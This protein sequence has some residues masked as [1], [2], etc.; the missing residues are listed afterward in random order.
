MRLATFTTGSADRIGVVDVN[1][2]IIRH[3]TD[4]LAGADLAAVMARWGTPRT[5]P[6]DAAT[7]M[8][9]VPGE[10]VGLASGD[11]V[12]ISITGLGTLP[13]RIA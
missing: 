8:P 10:E 7:S 11:V 5:M 6:Q 9:A 3:A 1:Q 12:E 13:N 4:L 2:S